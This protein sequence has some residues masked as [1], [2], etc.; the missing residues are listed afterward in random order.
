M[1]ATLSQPT[2]VSSTS[3]T[4]AQGRAP[5]AG[6]VSGVPH[7]LLRLEGAIALAAASAAYAHLGG[8][9]G[10]FA[11]LFLLPDLSMLGY[12]AGPRWGSA[13]YNAAHTYLAP[14]LLAALGVLLGTNALVALACIWA[15]HVGFDRMLGYGLKYGTAFGDTHLGRKGR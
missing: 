7:V 13:A 5:L 11:L 3:A 10:T 8:R 15:A 12:L 6:A 4:R 14:A 2:F 1:K 9:W